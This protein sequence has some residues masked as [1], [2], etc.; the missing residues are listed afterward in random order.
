MSKLPQAP[1]GA[2][3]DGST[4][5]LEV[6]QEL[7][8]SRAAATTARVAKEAGRLQLVQSKAIESLRRQLETSNTTT[9]DAQALLRMN[10]EQQPQFGRCHRLLLFQL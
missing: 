8:E 4:I 1:E 5:L 3:V 2:V 10:Q 9:R 6:R 7:E